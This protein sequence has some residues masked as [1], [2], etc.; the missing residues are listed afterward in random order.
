MTRLVVFSAVRLF[1]DALVA[2]LTTQKCIAE[3]TCCHSANRLVEDVVAFEP[4]VVLF[5]VNGDKAMQEAYAL[6]SAVP[7]IPLLAIAIA[8]TSEKVI[9]CADAGFSG[10]VPRRASITELCM[11]VDMAKKGECKCHPR[12]T[13]SLLRELAQRRQRRS[14]SALHDPLTRR[15]C[16]ILRLLGRGHS[17][18]EIAR[19]L[20]VCLATVKNHVHSVL[21]KLNVGCRTEA[22]C[23]LRDDPSLAHSA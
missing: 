11:I 22:V 14:D 4:D 10:Y 18:K 15:E 19:E 16:E 8:E 13:G 23:R 1:G 21:L 12:I 9:A 17:N 20:G 2:C 3:V 6:N 5:D 7:D